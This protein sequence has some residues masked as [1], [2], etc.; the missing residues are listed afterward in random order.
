MF[1]VPSALRASRIEPAPNLSTTFGGARNRNCRSTSAIT[2][3]SR[4]NASILVAS[5]SLSLAID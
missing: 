4:V 1:A 2:S 3:S 5:R